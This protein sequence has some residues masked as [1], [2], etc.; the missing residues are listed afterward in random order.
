MKSELNRRDR[1][2]HAIL[3]ALA[4]VIA[5]TGG[6]GFS[7]Q[8]VAERAGVTHRTVYNHFPTRDALNDALAEH[9]EDVMA[10]DGFREPPATSSASLVP[11][12]TDA[13][14]AFQSHEV[15]S[16]AY[17]MLMLASR[18]PAGVARRRTSAF[19]AVIARDTSPPQPD[20]EPDTSDERS[21]PGR[22]VPRTDQGSVFLR[23]TGCG[24][25]S[26]VPAVVDA[27]LS[28]VRPAE[29]H[30]V[31]DDGLEDR[32]ELEPGTADRPDHLVRRGLLFEQLGVLAREFVQPSVSRRPGRRPSRHRS[33]AMASVRATPAS[34]GDRC[35]IRPSCRM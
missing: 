7:V 25:E 23:A 20:S 4:A 10:R 2:R 30:G 1:T 16:R 21:L 27:D 15:L 3:D 26:E 14:A 28:R 13:Y 17:V 35:G 19:E 32:P 5:E 18:R 31:I 8:Q 6:L 9:V 24:G 29:S 12:I 11:M 22:D 33:L 34:S